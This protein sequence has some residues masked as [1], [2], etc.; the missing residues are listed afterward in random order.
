ML[1]VNLRRAQPL[2]GP[3]CQPWGTPNYSVFPGD[4]KKLQCAL[5][6]PQPRS[7]RGPV[8]TVSG[9]SQAFTSVLHC[10]LPWGE[11]GWR[12]M[13]VGNWGGHRAYPSEQKGVQGAQTPRD[14]PHLPSIWRMLLYQRG[15]DNKVILG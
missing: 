14:L 11:E 1:H 13:A 4:K 15:D 9:Q 8:V 12:D 3:L 6:A 5:P 7:G 10:G 2:P